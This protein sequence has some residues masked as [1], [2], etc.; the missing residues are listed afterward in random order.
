MISIIRTL[1]L[2]TTVIGKIMRVT[3]TP[4]IW[5]AVNEIA[6]VKDGMTKKMLTLKAHNKAFKRDSCRVAFLVCSEFWW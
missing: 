1:T 4:S 2:F 5:M 6:L 3:R